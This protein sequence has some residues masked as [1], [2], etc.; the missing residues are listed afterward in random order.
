MFPVYWIIVNNLLNSLIFFVLLSFEVLIVNLSRPSF[1]V[2]TLSGFVV[3]SNL[4]GLPK[5]KK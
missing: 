1:N 5:N 4:D 3:S 2:G